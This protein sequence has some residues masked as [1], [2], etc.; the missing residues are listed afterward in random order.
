[1]LS[2]KV[3]VQ[4][5]AGVGYSLFRP[6]LAS[7]Q[8][9]MQLALRRHVLICTLSCADP[10]C[11]D[12]SLRIQ[13]MD[14]AGALID[15]RLDLTCLQ[16]RRSCIGAYGCRH[17]CNWRRKNDL[18]QLRAGRTSAAHP[19]CVFGLRAEVQLAASSREPQLF[20]GGL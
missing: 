7:Q 4:H 19:D 20:S 2:I 12:F 8:A 18:G 1:M 15:N 5:P 9:H 14:I 16:P 10:K 11:E 3:D 6:L 13:K 17:V